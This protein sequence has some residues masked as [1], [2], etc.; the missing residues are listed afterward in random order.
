MYLIVFFCMRV[1]VIVDRNESIPALEWISY[2]N[3]SI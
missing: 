2:E 1:D 3:Y